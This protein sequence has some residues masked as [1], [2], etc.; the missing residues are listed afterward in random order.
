MLLFFCFLLGNF[1][2]ILMNM[3]LVDLVT[4]YYYKQC[5][6]L[7]L[8]LWTITSLLY[9][10][11][12]KNIMNCEALWCIPLVSGLDRGRQ[13]DVYAFKARLVY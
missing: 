9:K 12:H 4:I 5:Y 7:V 6:L 2:S 1:L 8:C 11:Y 10:I 3:N 13:V